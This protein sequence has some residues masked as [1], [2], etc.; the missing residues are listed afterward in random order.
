VQDFAQRLAV[1]ETR[2]VQDTEALHDQ[3]RALESRLDH[4]I[5]SVTERIGENQTAALEANGAVR[6][7]E[8]SVSNFLLQRRERR[9]NGGVARVPREKA[10]PPRA[11]DL[12][13]DRR[14]A[15]A[16]ERPG[17]CGARRPAH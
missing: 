6:S 16:G 11:G 2:G 3:T 15:P 1:N 7:I 8:E 12:V 13:H 14:R 17:R 10:G 5:R 9:R 4:A